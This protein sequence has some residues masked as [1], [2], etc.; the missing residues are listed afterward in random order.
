MKRRTLGQVCPEHYVS[1]YSK[2]AVSGETSTLIRS[3]PETRLSLAL[4]SSPSVFRFERTRSHPRNNSI[5]KFDDSRSLAWHNVY[6]L[7]VMVIWQNQVDSIGTLTRWHS[8]ICRV[9]STMQYSTNI[10]T[11]INPESSV[12]AQ[13][14]TCPCD[15][16][17]TNNL[18]VAMVL[19][20]I[21]INHV[22]I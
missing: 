13:R 18:C 12:M 20:L 8:H 11:S 14:S 1:H 10:I 9:G 7:V 4:I 5:Q 21:V 16:H 17:I 15:A 19:S 22:M 2:F 3:T 6:R